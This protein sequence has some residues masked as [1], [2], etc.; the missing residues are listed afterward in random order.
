MTHLLRPLTLASATALAGLLAVP[1]FAQT[2]AADASRLDQ[3]ARD[4]ARR[5]A[6]ERAATPTLEQ[7]RQAAGTQPLGPRVELTLEGAVERALE[8]NLDISVERLNPQTF[9]FAIAALAAN[10]RPTF[11][12]NFGLRSNS[13]FARSTTAGATNALG[14][15]AT[16]TLTSNQGFTQAMRWGGGSYAVGWNNSRV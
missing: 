7:A 1:A 4:A 2:P 12:S 3:I 9:D 6:D 5:F 15:V 14:L 10:Y 11:T 13:Q 16:D 8:R